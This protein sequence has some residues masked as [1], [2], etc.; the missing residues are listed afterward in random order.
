MPDEYVRT[1]QV[2]EPL[3][4]GERDDLVHQLAHARA[5]QAVDRPVEV[6]VLAPGEVGMEAGAE[7]EQR[8]DPPAASTRPEVG[9]MIPE[10]MRSSVVLPEPL[11]P[12]RPTASPG[13]IVSETSRSA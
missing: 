7:L 9:L 1:G 8:R 2:D 6:D 3:E 12:T 11:R 13:S 10:T 5:A 4:L